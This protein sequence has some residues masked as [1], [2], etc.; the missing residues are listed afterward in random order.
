MFARISK[1]RRCIEMATSLPVLSHGLPRAPDDCVAREEFVQ[2][3]TPVLGRVG[4][5][6]LTN[7][8]RDHH[9]LNVDVRKRARL[10]ASAGGGIPV[11]ELVTGFVDLISRSRMAGDCADGVEFAVGRCCE[12]LAPS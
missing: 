12:A 4:S 9:H 5:S 6:Y 1:F 2:G 8:F 10:P 11:G 3:A 7:S